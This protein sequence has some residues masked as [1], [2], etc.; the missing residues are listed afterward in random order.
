MLLGLI[1][2]TI[3]PKSSNKDK[4]RK[5]F[6]LNILLLGSIL[7]TFFTFVLNVFSW[8]YNTTIQNAITP[9]IIIVLFLF[10]LMLFFLSKRG[11]EQIAAILLIVF[12]Y[13]PA[14]YT[15]YT[16]GA[17]V[18]IV[19][20]IY[21]LLIIMS[22]ILI[23][24]RFAFFTTIVIISTSSVLAYNQALGL[25]HPNLS[26]MNISYSFGDAILLNIILMVIAVIAWLYTKEI[27]KSL[28]RARVSE[29]ALKKERD[30]LEIKV[31]E[32]TRDLKQA[33]LEKMTQ[34]YR[35]AE[36]GRLSSGLFHD[37]VT[38]LSLISLHLER[39]KNKREQGNINDVQIQLKK[40]VKAT[41]YLETFVKAVRKQLQNESSYKLFSLNK[42]IK[43]VMQ[44]LRHKAVTLGIKIHFHASKE[45]QLYGDQVKFSQL[46]INL[47]LNAID[48]YEGID[49][50][51]KDRR[52]QVSLVRDANGVTLTVSDEGMGIPSE[53]LK[54]IFKPFF[55]TKQVE[56]G[57][58]IG[59]SISQE[60]VEKHFGGKIYVRSN[61][62]AGTVFTIIF[63]VQKKIKE[64]NENLAHVIRYQ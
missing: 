3:Q 5:E 52:I 15:I 13:L 23:G 11:N 8:Y 21:A 33:Q 40:A 61:Q 10:L 6:I 60:I 45:I 53:N 64:K 56:K 14:T 17:Q 41:K 43:L 25:H 35:F 54:K 27:E 38:P 29:V 44:M 24:T 49:K 26:W 50:R 32:R 20:I 62:H 37:L 57:T 7:I 58:G 16:W 63:P 59:L 31:E 22:G 48:A 19:W 9:Q 36:I 34:L 30:L 12:F 1:Q 39:L 2:K 18:P 51:N 42:E 4:A 55:T 28:E 47:I 46:M